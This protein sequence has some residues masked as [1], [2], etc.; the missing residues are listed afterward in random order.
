VKKDFASLPEGTPEERKANFDAPVP[1]PITHTQATLI[2][3]NTR[4]VA[5]SI[6]FP[7]DVKR[8]DP[9]YPALLVA[10]SWLGQHRDSAGRLFMRLREARGL[11]YG[12]YAYIEYFPRGMF[13][14]E[15]EPNLARQQQIFQIWI[16]PVEPPTAVFSLRAGLFELDKMIQ[17]GIPP[18]EFDR[19]R[20]FLSKFVNVLT[21]SKSAELGYAID[22]LYY[23]IPGYNEYIRTALAKLTVEDVNRAIRKNLRSGNLQ[24]VG[25]S[26]DAA[27]LAQLLSSDAPSPIEYN[28]AKP[29]DVMEEDKIIERWPLHL[30]AEDIKIVPVDEVFE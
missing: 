12:D 6:G 15:P 24:I 23:G 5:W 8:G 1:A 2:D 30:R 10:A 9:D 14:M 25:V 19:A 27:K 7:L 4:S 18:E 22:S 17:H 26:K 11:N 13:L 20:G 21:K 28:S 3:K 16:R 29:K